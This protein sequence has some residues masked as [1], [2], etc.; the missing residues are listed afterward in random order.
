MKKTP[1]QFLCKKCLEKMRGYDAERKKVWRVNRLKIKQV[2]KQ[3]IQKVKVN[4]IK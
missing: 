4:I 2:G 1:Q 3:G